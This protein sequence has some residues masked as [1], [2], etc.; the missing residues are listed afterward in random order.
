VYR[1]VLLDVYGTLVHDDD[2]FWPPICAEVAARAGVTGAQVEREWTR[3]LHRS[4]DLAHG[5]AFRT[6]ADLNDAGLEEAAAH[7][8]VRVDAH[9]LCREQRAFWRRPPLFDDSLPFLRAVAVP[10]CLVSDAD[11]DD[12]A[13]VLT[14][15]GI[16]VDAVVTS[17]D[18]RA[19]KP[20]PE[21]FRRA[22]AQLGLGPGEV[23][24]IGDSPESD[25]VGAQALAIDAALVERAGPR[26]PAGAEPRYRVT[27]LTALLPLLGH[28]RDPAGPS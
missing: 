19:Y 24:H 3:C 15:H 13:A 25:V 6:L 2:A 26:P 20:R 14:R 8:G 23:L 11:R 18:A 27:S 1:G 9:R 22:L 5:D 28:R 7:F 17:Q 21:P 16:V 4:A 10:V 12:L